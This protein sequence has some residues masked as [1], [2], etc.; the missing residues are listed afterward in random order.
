MKKSL[1]VRFRPDEIEALLDYGDV[2]LTIPSRVTCERD[3]CK[4][5]ERLNDDVGDCQDCL[6]LRRLDNRR[7]EAHAKAC[8]LDNAARRLEDDSAPP[9]PE[10]LTFIAAANHLRVQA[11]Q[12]RELAG[13]LCEQMRESYRHD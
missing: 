10:R 6:E 13:F 11:M 7:L 8:S 2:C 4:W 12:M 1:T 3:I 5:H 9:G